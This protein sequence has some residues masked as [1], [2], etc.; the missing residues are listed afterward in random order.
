MESREFE[1]E[2][3]NGRVFVKIYYIKKNPLCPA[4]GTM[5]LL[6]KVKFSSSNNQ[7]NYIYFSQIAKKDNFLQY[8][9]RTFL[10]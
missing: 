1:K 9:I 6:W 2:R 3:T 4:K 8:L 5:Y 7:L 10:C